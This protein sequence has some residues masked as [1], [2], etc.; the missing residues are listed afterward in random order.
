MTILVTSHANHL[1]GYGQGG[2]SMHE[3]CGNIQVS[4]WLTEASAREL[5]DDI[6]KLI[7]DA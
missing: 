1:D 5:C 6:E 3:I 7:G 2:A 4:F